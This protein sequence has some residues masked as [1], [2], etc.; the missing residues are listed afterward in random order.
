MQT[1][2]TAEYFSNWTEDRLKELY[3]LPPYEPRDRVATWVR[4]NIRHRYQ[5]DLLRDLVV[6]GPKM[7]VCF[8]GCNWNRIV[9]AMNVAADH[10]VYN[11]ER[12]IRSLADHVKTTI[13][14][15][16]SKYKAGAVSSSRFTFDDDFIKPANDPSK[17]PDELRCKLSTRRETPMDGGEPEE[18]VDADLFSVNSDGE[19]VA[20]DYQTIT[21]GSYVVP[22]LSFRY[23]RN[24]ER[25]G[26]NVTLLK[27]IVYPAEKV[28]YAID[29]RDWHMDI[30]DNEV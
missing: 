20:V 10:N 3:V 24:G 23:Y 22:V 30:P 7:K 6:T 25:F 5:D 17:Y 4:G 2:P 9:F 26:L 18:I 19:E 11:F 16:P 27:G 12:W 8:S 21:A 29:N 14:A 1:Y 15:E 13:W 28:N